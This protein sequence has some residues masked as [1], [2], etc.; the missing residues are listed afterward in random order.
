MVNGPYRNRNTV[1]VLD[2]RGVVLANCRTQKAKQLINEG[3]AKLLKV[4]PQMTIQLTWEVTPGAEGDRE[5]VQRT[6][7]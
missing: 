7:S 1:K 5:N 3:K 6:E 2:S 4:F